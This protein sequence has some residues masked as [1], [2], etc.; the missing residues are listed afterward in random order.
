MAKIVVLTPEFKGRT[1][2][3]ATVL[4][5]VGRLED[6]SFQIPEQSV[7]S[8]HCEFML[9]GN[10]IVLKDLNSTNGTFINGEQIKAETIVRPGQVI[11]LGQVE[12]RIEDETTPP[13]SASRPP[14]PGAPPAPPAKPGSIPPPPAPAAS[15]PKKQ[16]DQTMVMTQGVKFSEA[17][18]G[19][20]STMFDKNS[21]FAKKSNKGTK[22]FII[23]VAAA[24]VIGLGV[25]AW[26]IFSFGGEK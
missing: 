5:T 9:R 1:Y 26:L 16:M 2:E 21:P 8:H 10:D 24:F 4:T 7:S 22:L 25:V 18:Q 13:L 15:Q 20:K 11:R 3:L 14:A 12:V 23:L 17:D 6:N 19:A